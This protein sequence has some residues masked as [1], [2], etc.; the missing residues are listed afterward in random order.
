MCLVMKIYKGML[1]GVAGIDIVLLVVA[2]DENV[3]QTGEHLA[4]YL[5]LKRDSSITK[6]VY[7]TKNG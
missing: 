5:E 6:S 3:P 1:A 2:A 7:L 4:K